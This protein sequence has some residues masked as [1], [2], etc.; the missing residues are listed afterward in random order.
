MNSAEPYHAM[1]SAEPSARTRGFVSDEIWGVRILVFCG[2]YDPSAVELGGVQLP[3]PKEIGVMNVLYLLSRDE[4]GVEL[5]KSMDLDPRECRR[6]PKAKKCEEVEFI[7]ALIWLAKICLDRRFNS[8]KVSG[9]LQRRNGIGTAI[10]GINRGKSNGREEFTTVVACRFRASNETIFT[11]VPQDHV[12]TGQQFLYVFRY[13]LTTP[14]APPTTS[15]HV[16]CYTHANNIWHP[17]PDIVT[18][19]T[20]IY[21]TTTAL[22]PASWLY[23]VVRPAVSSEFI[24]IR[25]IISPGNPTTTVHD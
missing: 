9:A 24:I 2:E 22:R 15:S 10:A 3:G 4:G 5:D 12:L 21:L 18:T 13:A 7:F 1:N 8:A 19:P 11:A 25:I 20:L 17:V 23:N 6:P 16:I 14:V